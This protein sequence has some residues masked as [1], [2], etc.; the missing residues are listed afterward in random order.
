MSREAPIPVRAV[1]FVMY[2]GQDPGKLRAW[3]RRL[4]G[5]PRGAEWHRGWSELGTEP[6][7]LCI[8][9]SD[10]DGPEAW[11]WRRGAAVALAVDD[12]D[13]AAAACRRRRVRILAGPIETGVCWML[14]LEDP[15]G[16]PLVLHQRKD[17]TAG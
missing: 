3:Y 13:A 4:F 17:G 7:A 6:V 8:N 11:E 16:N 10:G 1:D 5:L 15:E 2:C 9:G 12:I 14:F